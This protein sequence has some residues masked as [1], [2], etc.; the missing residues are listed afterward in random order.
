MC[1]KEEDKNFSNELIIDDDFNH[2]VEEYFGGKF[3]EEDIDDYLKACEKTK[4]SLCV[5]EMLN[6]IKVSDA[7]GETYLDC[8]KK[9]FSEVVNDF[10]SFNDFSKLIVALTIKY[11]WSKGGGAVGMKKTIGSKEEI[12]FKSTTDLDPVKSWDEYFYNMCLQVSRN[13]K[14]LS[15]R[16]GSIIVRDK[17][18]IGT[19]YNGA[20]RGVPRCD[21]RWKIDNML[22][23]EFGKLIKE[24]KI[25]GYDDVYGKCPRQVLGFKSG[26][27]L[28]W[29]VAG[30]SEENAI[31]NCSRLGISTVGTK[32]YMTCFFGET[33]VVTKNGLVR[34]ENVNIG[35]WVLSKTGKFN[36]VLKKHINKYSGDLLN[37]KV[38]GLEI[39]NFLVTPDHV[40]FG[41]KAGICHY[42][43]SNNRS[44]FL[45]PKVK[46]NKNIQDLNYEEIKADELEETDYLYV[47]N[48]CDFF[49][50]DF[51]VRSAKERHLRKNIPDKMFKDDDYGWIVGMYI[52]EGSVNRVKEGKYLSS[53][54]F[55]LHKE[56]K[57]YSDRIKNFFMKFGFNVSVF[58]KENRR[59]VIINSSVF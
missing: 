8:K 52:A 58:V 54:V 25:S 15:R 39:F 36:K 18:V 21:E 17:T 20:P 29:C 40:L 22:M 45:C 19:G 42:K 56:E 53:I 3:V 59:R 12:N 26:E 55:S 38:E 10:F 50:L 57:T 11:L 6:I 34:I 16:I 24:G 9:I 23:V 43:N 1:C 27:G 13:S 2:D 51:D 30:H 37:I 46:C 49:T 32:M 41:K 5:I 4:N 31:I 28:D 48:L 7:L 47:P 14:C 44:C 35:D 33:E